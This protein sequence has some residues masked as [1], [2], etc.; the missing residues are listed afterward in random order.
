MTGDGKWRTMCVNDGPR[1]FLLWRVID[2]ATEYYG[3]SRVI[4]YGYT[5]ARRKARE[6][7]GAAA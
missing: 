1:P 5:G 2:G 4:L 7:N 3:A 6:L